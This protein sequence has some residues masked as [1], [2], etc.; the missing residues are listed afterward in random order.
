MHETPHVTAAQHIGPAPLQKCVGV[1][2][3]RILEDLAG[4]SP[5]DCSV[6]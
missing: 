1:L 3:V 6:R 5:E 4:I 2:V